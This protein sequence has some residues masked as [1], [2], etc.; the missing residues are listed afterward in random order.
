MSRFEM[1]N[2]VGITCREMSIVKRRFEP[3]PTRFANLV[4]KTA[5]INKWT[6]EGRHDFDILYTSFSSPLGDA[7]PIRSRRLTAL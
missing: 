7:K 6:T 2:S 3:L 5:G 4:P 1:A